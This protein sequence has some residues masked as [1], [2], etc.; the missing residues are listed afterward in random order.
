MKRYKLL[1]DLPTFKAG[2]KFYLDSNNN[3]RLGGSEII[4]YSHITLEKFPNILTDW[5]EEIPE[6]S[7][8]SRVAY[9]CIYYYVNNYGIVSCSYD[10]RNED[11][12]Y[13]YGIGNYFKTEE[14]AKAYRRYLLARQV[15]IDDADGGEYS[16]GKENWCT[17]YSKFTQGWTGFDNDIYHP[18]MIYFRT[19]ET[20]QKS[21][22]EHK[23]Q[24]DII[25]K[26]ETGEK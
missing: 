11:D 12:N 25:R 24:W 4:A 9:G 26:Y 6:P 2:D 10:Y 20:L 8:R 7:I 17:Y 18:G 5:F 15:L 1:K 13:L 22:R 21:L 19:R 23:G 16:Y 3:L 14:E